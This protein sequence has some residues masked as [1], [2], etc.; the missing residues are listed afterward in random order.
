MNEQL[1]QRFPHLRTLTQA[2]LK[3]T[4]EQIMDDQAN[5][6]S[7]NSCSLCVSLS[8]NGALESFLLVK[9]AIRDVLP[10]RSYS[11][12]VGEIQEALDKVKRAFQV[13]I[14]IKVLLYQQGSTLLPKN[15]VSFV[16]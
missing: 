10:G 2:V 12:R 3:Q 9:V 14:P 6:S 13:S 7:I 1:L 8:T 5:I 11:P 4:D 16:L 15:Q